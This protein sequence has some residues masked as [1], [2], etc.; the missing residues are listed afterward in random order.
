MAKI[1]IIDDEP[2]IVQLLEAA[3]T[4]QG[5]TV[6]TSNGGEEGA[7]LAKS[8]RPALIITD[9]NMP[10]GTGW[11]LIK[12]LKADDATKAIPIIAL[13]AHQT[14]GD[15]DEAYRSGCDAYV[16]KPIDLDKFLARVIEF[17]GQ[18]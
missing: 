18:P 5:H 10:G 15:R 17:V 7:G 6:I 9:M 16:T 12:T 14:D 11:D 4:G 8:Q 1:L 13:T 2:P 3:M